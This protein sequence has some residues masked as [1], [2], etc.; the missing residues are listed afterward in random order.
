LP[1]QIC[2]PSVALQL[3]YIVHLQTVYRSKVV[4]PPKQLVDIIF[5]KLQI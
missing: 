2:T 1:K 5:S 4:K 3:C